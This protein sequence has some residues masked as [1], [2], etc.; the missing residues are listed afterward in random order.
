[1][2][3]FFVFEFLHNFKNVKNTIIGKIAKKK[4][5]KRIKIEIESL[6]EQGRVKASR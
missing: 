1:M 6:E 5:N 4:D 3:L 2:K